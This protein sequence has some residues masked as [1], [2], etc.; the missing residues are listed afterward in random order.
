MLGPPLMELKSL[1]SV[2]IV[3]PVRNG[4]RYIVEAIESV[5]LQG[6]TIREVLVVDD[7][8]TDTT[9]QKV[10]GFSDPRVKLLARP[11]G[12][13][14]VSAVRNF[15]LSQARGEWTMFLDAD[16]RLKPGAIAALCA[17][18]S[19][20]EVVAVYGDYERIDEN[21]V[22]IG[23]RNLIRRR[24]KP[25]GFILQPLLGGNFIVNGGIMLVRT[26]IFQDFGGFDE[27]LRYA[28][29]WYGWCRLAAMRPFCLSARP[30]C[31]RLPGAQD[32][33][34]DEQAFD[35]PGL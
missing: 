24:E 13:Q 3:I 30:P 26:R 20:P 11:Q 32:E 23:R 25:D 14:G 31:A 15:G 18:I 34:D 6:E 17:G 8:S 29:D 16:D 33:R 7:G 22:K 21:G 19:G 10:E 12:R 27:T 9:A 28:E 5:L 2:S 35:L 1:V 4:E